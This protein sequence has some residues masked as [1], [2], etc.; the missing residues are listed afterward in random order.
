[1]FDDLRKIEDFSWR[2]LVE[3]WISNSNCSWRQQT[4]RYT[5]TRPIRL[6]TKIGTIS[7]NR[8]AKTKLSVASKLVEQLR[9]KG[10]STE[11]HASYGLYTIVSKVVAD[12]DDLLTHWRLEGIFFWYK[13]L[14]PRTISEQTN[15]GPIFREQGALLMFIGTIL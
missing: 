3:V 6:T 13:L 11:N 15:I 1:M 14:K 12:H 2:L 4:F 9:N 8:D 7:R 10:P 5:C